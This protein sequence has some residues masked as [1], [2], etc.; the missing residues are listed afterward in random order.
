M[1]KLN[2]LLYKCILTIETNVD[3]I[4][5]EEVSDEGIN[6]KKLSSIKPN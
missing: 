4:L 3:R 6:K 5:R 1:S 2:Q